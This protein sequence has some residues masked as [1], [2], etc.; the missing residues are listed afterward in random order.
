MHV[1]I[2]SAKKCFAKY[3]SAIQVLRMGDNAETGTDAD[4]G[5]GIGSNANRTIHSLLLSVTAPVILLL[6]A[7]TKATMNV[8]TIH[9]SK[10]QTLCTGSGGGGTGATSTGRTRG[11]LQ[12]AALQALY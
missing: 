9:V 1:T 3:E 6:S 2:D 7:L 8:F 10:Q 11:F 4:I 5:N 12:R